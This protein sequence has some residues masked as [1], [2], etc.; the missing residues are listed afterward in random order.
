MNNQLNEQDSFQSY[1]INHWKP[2]IVAIIAS[3]IVLG[4]AL[5]L[6]RSLGLFSKPTTPTTVPS[7]T[8]YAAALGLVGTVLSVAV[9]LIGVVIKYSIDDRNARQAEI[10]SFRNNVLKE[11]AEDRN[12]IEASI[13]AVD[14]LCENNKDTT[15]TQ[16]GGALLALVNLRQYGLAV[17]LLSQLWRERKVPTSVAD[18]VLR[19]TLIHGKEEDRT[20]AGV[21][22]FENASKIS[23]EGYHIWPLPEWRV[24]LPNQCRSALVKTASVWLESQIQKNDF[25]PADAVRVLYQALED[26]DSNIEDIARASL[27]PVCENVPSGSWIR[28]PGEDKLTIEMIEVKVKKDEE[29]TPKSSHAKQRMDVIENIYKSMQATEE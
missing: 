19:K 18:E 14:L 20:N 11:E 1:K 6:M 13:R 25:M 17:S 9:T 16:M 27:K 22:L 8:A 26:P 28:V 23:Q 12:R 21:V 29:Y 5:I 7:A 10:D 15:K 2:W 4:V 24:D 3:S